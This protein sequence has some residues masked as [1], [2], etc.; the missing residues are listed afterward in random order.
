MTE[1]KETPPEG[2]MLS[3]KAYS[4]LKRGVQ[5]F[6]PAIS[7]LYF[8]LGTIWGLPAVE[9]VIGTLA[10]LATFGGVM[11]G[12][13]SKHYNSN[14]SNFDGVI[15]IRTNGEGTKV[16]SLNL[17]QPAESIDEMKTVTFK[18]GPPQE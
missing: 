15:E 12:I 7:T 13:S 6:I 1:P 5:I 9:Q 8:T 10:A 2:F 4:R 11:L 17:N 3:D 16:Y 18:V 14:A